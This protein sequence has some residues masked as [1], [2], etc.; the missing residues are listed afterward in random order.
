MIRKIITVLLALCMLASMATATVS[1]VSAEGELTTF[2]VEITDQGDGVAILSVS[3]PAGVATGKIVIGTSE[4]LTF[5]P[6]SAKSA[7]GLGTINES[8]NGEDLLCITFA[9]T[10]AVTK[11]TEVLTAQYNIKAGA[12]LSVDDIDVPIWTLTDGS[13][14]LGTEADGDVEKNVVSSRTI[15]FA[16]GN[17]GSV[18]GES[19]LQVAKGTDLSAIAFPELACDKNYIFAGWDKTEGTVDD[20]ITITAS[21]KHLGDVTGDGRANSLDAAFILRY[22]AG[23]IGEDKL[24]FSVADV[25]GDG[26]INSQDAA[27]VLRFD[28]ALLSVFPA[29]KE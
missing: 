3:I 23:L 11:L 10:Y 21:F 18:K 29:W 20:D 9:E 19:T 5:V 15:T 17:G 22:D 2:I 7:L 25:T 16:A 27:F 8:Y 12:V 4:N 14:Y 24:D 6:G 13:E 28:A 1:T 26:K